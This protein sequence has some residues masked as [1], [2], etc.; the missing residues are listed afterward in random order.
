MNTDSAISLLSEWKSATNRGV[1]VLKYKH[2][3]ITVSVVGTHCQQ[4]FFF[5]SIHP[6][7]NLFF[8]LVIAKEWNFQSPRFF[9]AFLC[10]K[11]ATT[12]CEVWKKGFST[13]INRLKVNACIYTNA[14]CSVCLIHTFSKTIAVLKFYVLCTYCLMFFL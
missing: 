5:F 11:L 8:K 12:E 1:S 9:I 7:S 3:L 14:H 6:I 4:V 2:K 10:D 13:K